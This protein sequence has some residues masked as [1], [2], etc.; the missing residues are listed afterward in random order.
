MVLPPYLIIS[1]L[2]MTVCIGPS[3]WRR[4]AASVSTGVFLSGILAG[5]VGATVGGIA[6]STMAYWLFLFFCRFLLPFGDIQL[7]MTILLAVAYGGGILGAAVGGK[8]LYGWGVK[9]FSTGSEHQPYP[10]QEGVIRDYEQW[11]Q[12]HAPSLGESEERQQTSDKSDAG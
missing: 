9:R 7:F 5:I 1:I 4:R 12:Q 3:L 8:L 11:K 2:V 6:G 10:E